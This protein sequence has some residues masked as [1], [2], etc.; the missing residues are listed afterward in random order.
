M[1]KKILQAVAQ[2][3]LLLAPADVR[4][5]LAVNSKAK[6]WKKRDPEVLQ[7]MV[8][9]QELGWGK[10][11][12]VARY[13]TGKNSHLV[14]GGTRSIAYTFA[15]RRNGQ[16]V[17]C[18]DLDRAVWSQGFAGRPGDENSEFLSVLFEGL[19]QGEGV[20][21]PTAGE[22]N[23][24]QMLAGLSLWTACR[25]LWKWKEDCLHGHFHFG[26]PACPGSTLQSLIRA[27]RVNVEKPPKLKLDTVAA[28]QKALK[29]LGVYSGAVDGVW[30]PMSKGALTA[31]QRQAG[32]AADGVWGPVTEAAIREKLG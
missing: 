14:Q 18:N 3:A 9:H 21:D 19:F 25:D 28:R 24:R 32:L 15:V 5:K 2:N 31:F 20:N 11:E 22:P 29:I 4:S 13:H 10:I 1:E 17:L 26:K 23:S 6:D 30:G 12:D 7:G 16:I 8:W 27:V